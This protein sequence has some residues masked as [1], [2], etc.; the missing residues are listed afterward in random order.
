MSQAAADTS[1]PQV[2]EEF[3][4]SPSDDA[5]WEDLDEDTDE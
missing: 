3:G 1:E 4:Y 5:E 2:I